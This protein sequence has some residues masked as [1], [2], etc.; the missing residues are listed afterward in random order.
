MSKNRERRF[1]GRDCEILGSSPFPKNPGH[2]FPP[3][4]TLVVSGKDYT[5]VQQNGTP[6]QTCSRGTAITNTDERQ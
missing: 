3:V 4:G 5:N 2:E 1:P 6:L